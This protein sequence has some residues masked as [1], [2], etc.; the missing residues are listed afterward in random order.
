MLLLCCCCCSWQW[1]VCWVSCLCWQHGCCC[2]EWIVA[3]VGAAGHAE[4]GGLG[5]AVCTA[6]Q[7]SADQ[8][9]WHSIVQQDCCLRYLLLAAAVEGRPCR[10]QMCTAPAHG[11]SVGTMMMAHETLLLA[12]GMCKTMYNKRNKSFNTSMVRTHVEDSSGSP[13]GVLCSCC[14]RLPLAIRSIDRG[15]LSSSGNCHQHKQPMSTREMLWFS[16]LAPTLNM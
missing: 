5:W 13:R 6:A 14:S 7:T 12:A 4:V 8:G 15:C 9:L 11:I 3:A 2:C 16:K 10:Q 1:S